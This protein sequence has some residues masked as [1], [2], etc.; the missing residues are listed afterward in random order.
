MNETEIIHQLKTNYPTRIEKPLHTVKDIISLALSHF[1]ISSIQSIRWH[2]QYFNFKNVTHVLIDDQWI[3]KQ[4]YLEEMVKYVYINDLIYLFQHPE[5]CPNI[6]SKE[7]GLSIQQLRLKNGNVVKNLP[8][9][10][11]ASPKTIKSNGN[12]FYFNSFTIAENE[13]YLQAELFRLVIDR[14]KY[15]TLHFHVEGNYG[16]DLIPVHF[17]LMALCGQKEKW[18]TKYHIQERNFKTK[19]LFTRLWDPWTY[20]SFAADLNISI[21]TTTPYTGKVFLY[22]NEQCGSATWYFITYLIYAFASKIFRETQII[23]GRRIK[24]GTFTSSQLK[25]IGFSSTSSGD[26][27]AEEF[28]IDKDTTITVPLQVTI[29]RSIKQADWSRF[30]LPRPKLS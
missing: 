8:I 24:T 1:T 26:G 28:K 14:D 13:K 7:F 23:H 21:R 2:S 12:V 20:E 30:W 6:L 5:I 19:K 27:N 10:Y 25:L 3:Q 15:D 16:G 11:F 9:K 18:M 17:I 29:K 22:V 4:I